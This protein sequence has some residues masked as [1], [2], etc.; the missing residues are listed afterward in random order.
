[1]SPGYFALLP[2]LLGGNLT[3]YDGHSDHEEDRGKPWGAA[4]G[5]ALLVQLVT[6]AGIILIAV[7]AIFNKTGKTSFSKKLHN[8]IVPSF[9]AGALMATAVFLIIP[10]SM[11]LLQKAAS[12][13]TDDH[14]EENEVVAE[15]DHS[16]HSHSHMP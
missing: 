13:S 6:F 12:A 1:M 9:A 14:H 3:D 10:E 7:T 4:I 15:D 5:A 16:G 2:R 8:I 11:A